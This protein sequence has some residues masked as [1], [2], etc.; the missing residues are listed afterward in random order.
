MSRL[1][2]LAHRF[3]V[4]TTATACKTRKVRPFAIP[5]QAKPAPETMS[6]QMDWRYIL[7]TRVND[8]ADE[9]RTLPTNH[10]MKAVQRP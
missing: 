8:V 9:C 3:F 2:K 10:C 6:G 5:G 4:N 7:L 1:K